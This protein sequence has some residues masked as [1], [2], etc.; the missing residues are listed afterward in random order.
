MAKRAVE[1]SP[2][3]EL[4][5]PLLGSWRNIYWVVMAELGVL[6]LLFYALTRWAA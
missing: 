2:A 4:P 5:P 6:I 1:K 3:P